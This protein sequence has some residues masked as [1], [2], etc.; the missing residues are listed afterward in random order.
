MTI[1]T[2]KIASYN[3]LFDQSADAILIFTSG[4]YTSNVYR[5]ASS[6]NMFL[7]SVLSVSSRERRQAALWVSCTG[8]CINACRYFFS[9]G[10]VLNRFRASILG[11][12]K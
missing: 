4:N 2:V 8:M 3:E 10:K 6:N 5:I 11:P 9:E 7:N 1:L 12:E